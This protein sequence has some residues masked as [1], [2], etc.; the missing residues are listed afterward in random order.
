MTTTITA[1]AADGEKKT[2][3]DSVFVLEWNI[4][5][6]RYPKCWSN[7]YYLRGFFDYMF[8]FSFFFQQFQIPAYK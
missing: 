5:A 3:I 2:L 7:E 4:A 1:A 6:I 8:F